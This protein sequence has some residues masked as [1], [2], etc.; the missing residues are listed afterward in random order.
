[1]KKKKVKEKQREENKK[2]RSFPREALL[3]RREKK[4]L[5]KESNFREKKRV[6]E[7][8]KQLRRKK[9]IVSMHFVPSVDLTMYGPVNRTSTQ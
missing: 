6:R 7:E 1:M 2:W 5:M 3:P 4:N 9:L 8:K